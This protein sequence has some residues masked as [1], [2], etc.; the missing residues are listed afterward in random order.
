MKSYASIQVA[1]LIAVTWFGVLSV[2]AYGWPGPVPKTGQTQCY[3]EAGRAIGCDIAHGEPLYGQDG[4][5]QQGITSPE[6]R[7]VALVNP[8]DDTGTGGG[9]SGNGVCEGKERCNGTV[10]DRLTDLIW[11]ANT[12]CSGLVDWPTALARVKE[13]GHG[14]CGI[15]DGS[16]P[17]TWRLPNVKEL[18]SLVHYGCAVP[19]M[20]TLRTGCFLPYFSNISLNDQHEFYAA[21]WSA[22]SCPIDLGY[23]GRFKGA[24]RVTVMGTGG[25]RCESIDHA[26]IAVV[27]PVRRNR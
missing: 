23:Y 19:A 18:E 17:G 27:W 5:L 3:D 1:A 14:Q 12:D 7:F 26:Q 2:K 15:L 4:Q 8:S 13:L 9:I 22:T 25:S 24:M 11:L 6:P 16:K 10:Q 21:R 20:S